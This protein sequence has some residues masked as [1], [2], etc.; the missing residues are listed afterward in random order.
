MLQLGDSSNKKRKRKTFVFDLD[1]A[2]SN[3]SPVCMTEIPL[4]LSPSELEQFLKEQR[5]LR[6][7]SL[8]QN[9]ASRGKFLQSIPRELLEENRDPYPSPIYDSRGVQTNTLENRTRDKLNKELTFLIHWMIKN[10]ENFDPPSFYSPPK[11]AKRI[12]V[13]SSLGLLIGK[14][15]I[16]LNRI[17]SE[18]ECSISIRGAGTKYNF[19]GHLS[20]HVYVESD[21]EEKILKAVNL[22][23]P[24]IDPLHPDHELEKLKSLQQLA[25]IQGKDTLTTHQK[26]ML[27][28]IQEEQADPDKY[29]HIKCS[30][31]GS[32][33]H[34]SADCKV[35]DDLLAEFMMGVADLEDVEK[36]AT[37]KSAWEER[38]ERLK[39]RLNVAM[40]TKELKEK[41]VKGGSFHP[42]SFQASVR[43]KTGAHGKPSKPT[44]ISTQPTAAPWRSNRS[45]PSGLPP[46]F[47]K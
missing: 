42:L 44:P 37:E 28:S 6:L 7:L 27:D 46:S 19:D 39:S 32:V 24:L 33:G 43:P 18:S 41:G 4:G 45:I 22:I 25:L 5:L 35:S 17:R 31:C 20:Q 10:V 13:E 1:H 9:D 2:K 29:S 3:F 30:K 14:Q 34:V 23:E 26:G 36:P 12:F 47:P 38:Q 15:G 40:V 11:F 21:S 8:I 16:T